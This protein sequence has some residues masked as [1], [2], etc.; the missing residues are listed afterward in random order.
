MQ[1]KPVIGIPCYQETPHSNGRPRFMQLQTYTSAIIAAGGIPVLLPLQDRDALVTLCSRLD[2]VLLA[3]G[4]DVNPTRYGETAHPKT[5]APDDLRDTVEIEL[6]RLALDEHIPLLAICRG[7]QVLNVAAGGTLIQDIASLVPGAIRHEYDYDAYAARQEITHTV[8]LVAGSRLASI[9]GTSV[10]VN[11]YHHQAAAT[12]SRAFTPVG[13][14]PDGV[15]E[16][17]EGN[18]PAQ[19]VVA[20]QWH[21]EDMFHAHAPMLNLFKAYISWILERPVGASAR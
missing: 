18:D 11:S 12:L 16:A 17:F 2:G 19:F 6:A 15:L 10:G 20:V 14:A 5:E 9:M 8:E 7:L 13:Y 4:D 3:G 1:H 21:P